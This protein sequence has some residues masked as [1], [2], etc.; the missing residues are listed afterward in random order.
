MCAVQAGW[1]AGVHVLLQ[2]GSS[3]LARTP[4]G[5]TPLIWAAYKGNAEIV[6][7]L[8]SAGADVNVMGEL[9]NRPLHLAVSADHSQV[10]K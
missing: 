8:I 6:Q 7:A 1:V 2:H 4:A 10:K 3:V 5:D 9:G